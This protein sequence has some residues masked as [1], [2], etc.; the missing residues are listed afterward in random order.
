MAKGKQ[1]KVERRQ[2]IHRKIRQTIMGTP[3]RPRLSIYR[4][5][6]YI[7]AQLIDD[8]A[9][10]TLAAASSLEDGVDGEDPTEESRTV[11]KILAERAEE[12]GI[13]KAVF[14]RSGYKYH[15]RVKALAEGAREAGLNV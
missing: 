7:Y 8:F 12:K 15:G 6:K 1:E 9:G 3:G 5:N 14:D 2:R 10:H 11:G 4:S 13:S